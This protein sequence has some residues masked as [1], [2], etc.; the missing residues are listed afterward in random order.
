MT[1][2]DCKQPDNC[3]ATQAGYV[4]SVVMSGYACQLCDLTWQE[5]RD[6]G[7]RAA[8]LIDVTPAVTDPP[9]NVD[10]PY[11]EQV[12]DLL[13]CTMG[14]WDNEPTSY[15]YQW[16]SDGTATIG[17]DASQYTVTPDDA[18][19]TITCIVTATNA[20]GSTAAPPSNGVAIAEVAASK[21][22][23]RS[24]GTGHGLQH[25]PAHHPANR[26]AGTDRTR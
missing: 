8:T 5:Q 13:T 12:G 9:V 23:K 6:A 11:V 2:P 25:P 26:T 10:V 18:G 15:S 24:E 4:W 19:H 21:T 16:K 3:Q 17:T 14:N 20:I 7:S 1:H 22:T